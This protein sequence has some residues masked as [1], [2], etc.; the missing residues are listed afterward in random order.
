MA[1]S[2][3]DWDLLEELCDILGVGKYASPD[4]IKKA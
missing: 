3:E 2:D 4:E 1:D